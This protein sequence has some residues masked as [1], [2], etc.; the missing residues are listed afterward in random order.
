M[1]KNILLS[2]WFLLRLNV[3]TMGRFTVWVAVLSFFIS[4]GASVSEIRFMA[5]VLGAFVLLPIVDF[6]SSIVNMKKSSLQNCNN[7]KGE[8][9]K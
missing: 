6:Y 5:V 2:L 9:K 1:R 3:E 7:D 8:K 4:L